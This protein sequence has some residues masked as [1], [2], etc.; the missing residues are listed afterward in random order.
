MEEMSGVETPGVEMDGDDNVGVQVI[1]EDV[2]GQV[3]EDAAVDEIVAVGAL[4]GE[5]TPGM[6]MEARTATGRGPLEKVTAWSVS[7]SVATQ[8]NGMGMRS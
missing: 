2:G 6:E 1:A 8:R 7:R 3:V 5:K 4:T